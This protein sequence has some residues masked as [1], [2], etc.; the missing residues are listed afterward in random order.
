MTASQQ[1]SSRNRRLPYLVGLLVLIGMASFFFRQPI[2]RALLF[3]S[4]LRADA[5]S[6]EA[7]QEL[8][9]GAQVPFVFLQRVWNAQK[10]PHRSLVATYL[11]ENAGARP[12]LYR[13]AEPLLLSAALDVDASVRELALGTLAEQ[14]HPDLPRLAAALLRDADP[15]MRL[16]GLQYLRKQDPS[17]A[18]GA[19][20]NLL[21]DPDLR[22]VTTAD[23]AL[24]NWTGEDFGIRISQAN[25]NLAYDAI[26]S[27]DPANLKIIQAGVR[28]WKD[29]WVGHRQNYP[30]NSLAAS[31][32]PGT[33]DRLPTT[34][35]KLADLEGKTVRFSDFKGKTVLLNF[36]TTWC[37]GCLIEIPYLIELQRRNADRLAVVGISLDGQA[38]VDEHGHVAEAHS[39]D[40]DSHP[41]KEAP[42]D[43][44]EIRAKIVQFVR[45]KGINYPVLLD[46]RSEI[47]R[48]FNGGELPTNVLID[49]QGYVRRR[50]VGGRA[51]AALEAMLDELV[52]GTGRATEPTPASR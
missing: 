31:G 45:D 36:W 41:Q 26:S 18:L 17:A 15:Q 2:Q 9:E 50:F 10:I 3:R 14:K 47:G 44:A 19:V 38:E 35:F 12:E 51:V 1:P 30:T 46:P 6:E 25:L 8:A 16:L 24:R 13:Q 23:S 33:L 42:D 7:F 28:H 37:P 5:P 39:D 21:D 52:P 4:I 29:W 34:N 22:V 20:F 11:K 49:P 43:P 32:E 40:G 48:R 27:V